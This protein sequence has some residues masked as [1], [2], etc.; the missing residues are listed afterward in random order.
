MAFLVKI[1]LIC[2]VLEMVFAVVMELVLTGSVFV[3]LNI[4]EIGVK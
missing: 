2:F 3:I 4:K 1:K